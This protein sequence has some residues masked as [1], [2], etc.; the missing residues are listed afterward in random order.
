LIK[1]RKL[2]EAKEL[3]RKAIAIDEKSAEL[4]LNLGIIDNDQFDYSGA[5]IR[6][7]TAICI[8]PDYAELYY[9][10]GNTLIG[11]G[12]LVD[13]VASYRR[14]LELNPD[15]AETYNNLGNALKDL[16]QLEAAV[17][18]YSKALE[19][20]PNF[21]LM[22]IN[23]G[24]VLI[25]LGLFDAAVASYRRALEIEPGY[26][27]MHFNLGNIL[28]DLGQLVDAAASYR[29]ALELEPYYA[30]AHYNLG[31]ALKDLGQLDNAV[32]SYSRAREIKHDFAEAHYNLG[33]ALNEL[34][35][36]DDALASYH[37]ALEVKPDFAE[38]HNN[39]GNV[40][41]DLNRL[42]DAEASY[43]R[44]IAVMPSLYDA[45]GNLGSA[46]MALGKIDEAKKF[47]NHAI[48][49]APGEAIPLATALKHFPFRHDDPRFNHLEAAYKQRG[50]LPLKDKIILNFA[51][52]K[53]ME[54]IGQYEL[55]FSAYEEGNRLHYMGR[56]F[57]ET[58]DEGFLKYTCSIFNDDVFKDCASLAET[59][60]PTQDERVPIFVV[61]MPRSGSTL[62]EQIL[63]S[64]SDIFGAGE[65][66]AFNSVAKKAGELLHGPINSQASLLVLRQLGQEYLDQV[67]KLVPENQYVIDKLLTNYCHLGLIHLM[68][69]NAKIIHSTRAP[70]DTCFSCYALRFT[71]GHEYSYDPGVLGRKY[72]RYSKLMEHWH[73]GLPNGRILDVRYEDCV[74][75]PEREARRMLDYLGL[76][77]DPSCLKFHENKRP[78]LTASVA[79][80]RKPIYSSSVA[81]WKHF[82]KNLSPLLEII[83]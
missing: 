56:P 79:Q 32:T 38:A 83:L 48:E 19:I 53:A 21:A 74:A 37:K 20:R 68:L 43:R 55:S 42:G 31:N 41:L 59:L 47:I 6:I 40:L 76:P 29:R 1:Q 49:M 66:T 75:N 13:A 33:N 62:I 73:N 12:Q 34:R 52:G 16:G 58:E 80:V 70:M 5:E 81:R 77:W 3:C 61:G 35:L 9:H 11:L 28:K 64:H 30:E 82:A 50:S 63:S 71:H 67:W 7:R 18:S 23:L 57:D 14:A 22:L 51:M 60:P 39:L 8:N 69:P 2:D 15:N 36:L 10:L 65:I 4:W 24:N 46:L 27:E 54:D 26:A 72:L 44:S 45:Y 17:A 78:V 25:D